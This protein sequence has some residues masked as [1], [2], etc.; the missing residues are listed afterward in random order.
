MSTAKQ[1]W[2]MGRLIWATVVLFAI[3][4]V[5]MLSIAITLNPG[6]GQLVLALPIFFVLLFLVVFIGCRLPVE[7]FFLQPKPHFAD[8]VTRGPPA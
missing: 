4:L 5:V 7:A 2:R 6:H 3:A 8:S 1:Q